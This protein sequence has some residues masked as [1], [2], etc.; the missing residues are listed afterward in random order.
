M[1]TPVSTFTKQQTHQLLDQ[2]PSDRLSE[3]SLFLEQLLKV[4]NSHVVNQSASERSLPT[5]EHPWLKFAGM[6]GED[7]DWQT[8]QAGIDD[9]RS[10]IDAKEGVYCSLS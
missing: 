4:V 2:F 5:E 6:Y 9:Y 1:T 8:F 10:E 3:I 7:F